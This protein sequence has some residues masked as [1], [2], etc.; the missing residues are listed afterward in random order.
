MSQTRPEI[1]QENHARS[2]SRDLNQ[3]CRIA[4]EE[5][6]QHQKLERM[7]RTQLIC[8]MAFVLTVK[9]GNLSV[10]S[11]MENSTGY[12]STDKTEHQGLCY[13]SRETFPAL[14]WENTIPLIRCMRLKGRRLWR[15]NPPARTL[16][17]MHLLSIAADSQPWIPC[18]RTKER[19]SDIRK[20]KHD[21]VMG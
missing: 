16:S 20:W 8:P 2:L 12:R 21:V 9:L 1:L 5:K 6:F 3:I 10:S 4:T 13:F 11:K 14:V 18:M 17:A 19:L 7:V 15:L